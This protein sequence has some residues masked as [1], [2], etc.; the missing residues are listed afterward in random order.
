MF[1]SLKRRA[2]HALSNIYGEGVS[3]PVIPDDSGYVGFF[4]RIVEHLEVGA[5]KV[6]ALAREKSRDLLGQAASD[7][8]SHLLRLNTD[9]DF[10]SVLGPVPETIRAALAEWVKVHM[11]DLVTRLAPKDRG[12]GSDDDMSL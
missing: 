12:M 1:Q 6:L 5:E 8:F 11:E 10:A 9:F 3:G 4:F 7:V 2:S